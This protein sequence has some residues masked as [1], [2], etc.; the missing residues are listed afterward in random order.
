MQ[1]QVK[2][3]LRGHLSLPALPSNL[4]VFIE[5][6]RLVED[7]RIGHPAHS[8]A[9]HPLPTPRCIL[10]MYRKALPP[11]PILEPLNND[12]K[13]HNEF[14]MLPLTPSPFERV[15]LPSSIALYPEAALP[16][17]DL[18]LHPLVGLPKLTREG[19]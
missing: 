16:A 9:S 18:R 2:G 12:P 1:P 15:T 4:Q 3:N 8:R 14:Q 17:D 7:G 5:R 6:L 11:T 19:R 10:I 13:T